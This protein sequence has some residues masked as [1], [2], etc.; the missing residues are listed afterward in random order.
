MSDELQRSDPSPVAEPSVLDYVKSLLK[1]GD[2]EK[3]R[4]PEFVEEDSQPLPSALVQ[5]EESLAVSV[6]PQPHPFAFA[7]PPSR[8]FPW[9]SLVAL[10]LALVAQ[11]MFEP[12]QDA[13]PIGIILYILSFSFLGWGIDRREWTLA[14]HA[15]PSERAD[16]LTY[17][18]VP[19]FISMAFALLAFFLFGGNL[20]T[21]GNVIL[22]CLAVAFFVYACWLNAAPLREILRRAGALLRRDPWTVNIPRWSL[23]LLAATVLV[24]FFRFYQTGSV[25][26]EPFSDHAEKI[27]DVYDVSQ[28]QPHIFFIRNTGREGFQMYWTLLVAKVF[29]TGLSFLSLKLGTAILGFL[30]LPF[31]Y[32]LGKEI[33]GPRVGL[34]AFVLAGIAYW[35]NIISR[36]GLRFPLYPL[37]VAPTLLYLIRGLRTRNRND[38]LLSGLFLGLGL[39][40]YSPMRIVPIVVVVAFGLYWLHSQSKDAR[41]EVIPWLA[42]LALVSLLVF[43][44]LLRYWV[45]DPM[46]FGFRALSRLGGVEQ[47]LPGPVHEIFLSN[48]WN[49]LKM[50]NYDDGEIWVHSVTHRPALDVVSGALLLIGVVLVL[51]RY[52]RNRH[53]L[54][55]FLLVSIPLLLMPS[56]LSL[57]FPSENPALNRAG[58]AYVPVFIIAALALDGL[59][60]SF[61]R[62]RA[63][64]LVAWL[65]TG[66]LLFWSASQN[67][68]LIFRQY[69]ESF[70]QASW[71]TSDM[72]RLLKQFE[73]TYG[74]TDTV[75]VVPFEHWVDTRLPAVWAGIPNRDMA[76]WR[77]NIPGTVELPGPKLFMVKANL[78]DPLGNDEETLDVL[79]SVYPDGQLRMF[80][81]DVPGHDFW[82]FTVPDQ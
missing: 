22:W 47:P 39:H 17:R 33:G 64:S 78:E 38:F 50:F 20:F 21:P 10:V 27:L 7:L 55:L 23:V 3:I 31:I 69:H 24:F 60:T 76:M 66:F 68:D 37:F 71:N 79:Q 73:L 19:L 6:E 14:P 61:G 43:L 54:D 82:I 29:G 34:L 42:M 9:R 77:E 8:P 48:V 16:P 28:G 18:R 46:Q 5:P 45:D 62:G 13:T 41:R 4:I 49:A 26:A 40:G 72:G 2:G 53:W 70:R 11:A 56:I 80:D 32:L 51:V 12:P 65:L 81:S 1:F 36:V 44:P 63:R 75:W 35:P 74:G 59:V 67:Y 30:T 57:A 25:P 52:I 58:G 15:L